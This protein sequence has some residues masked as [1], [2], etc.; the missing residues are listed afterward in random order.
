M[1]SY[2]FKKILMVFAEVVLFLVAVLP[3][4]T[5]AQIPYIPLEPLPGT[6]DPATKQATIA[7][8]L[9]AM[10]QL[11]IGVAG[12]LAVI[13]IV[14]GGIQYLTTDAIQDK[15]EGKQRIQDALWGLILAIGAFIILNTISPNLLNFKLSIVSVPQITTTAPGTGFG[16]VGTNSCVAGDPW[17]DDTAVRSHLF[18]NNIPVNKNN[19]KTVGET[20]CTSVYALGQ[21]A[22][23]GTIQLKKDCESR[24]NITCNVVITGGTEYW[25]HGNGSANINQNTTQHKPGNSVVDIS[26]SDSDLNDFITNSSKSGSVKRAP[27][28]QGGC[29]CSSLGQGWFIGNTVYVRESSPDHWH[30][31]FPFSTG[32][33]F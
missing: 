4:I 11:I 15:K 2:N 17:P 12:V 8:Y 32:G 23:S 5:Y 18:S 1:Q 24:G 30:V 6:Y 27:C 28:S 13:M 21:G 9:P 29:T 31:C 22:I 25:I 3:F 33:G 10:F 19:C 14:W 20:N 16:C 7:T 26:A